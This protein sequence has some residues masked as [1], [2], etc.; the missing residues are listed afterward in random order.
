[1]NH[2][3]PV[4]AFTYDTSDLAT[5]R[6]RVEEEANDWIIYVVDSGQSTHL[7]LCFEAAE[8]AGYVDP[9]KVR[10]DHVNFGVVLGEDKKKFKS[11]SGD[12]VKLKDLLD[13]GLKKSEQ[14]RTEKAAERAERGQA[15]PDLTEAEQVAANEAIAYSCIKYADLSQNRT[16]DYIFSYDKML[17]EKGNTAIYLINAYARCKQVS[18]QAEVLALPASARDGVA[19]VPDDAVEGH[20]KLAQQLIRFPSML[21]SALDELLPSQICEYCYETASLYHEFYGDCRIISRPKDGPATVEISRLLI[22]E[23]AAK[24]MA[25]CFQLIGLRFVEKM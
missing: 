12:T 25:T 9:A 21:E 11:R 19:V 1:M 2:R 3:I 22:T 15:A 18:A 4:G 5:L 7:E 6:Y 14:F 23:A 24:V 17:N 8:K 20:W 13:E 10:I 16:K